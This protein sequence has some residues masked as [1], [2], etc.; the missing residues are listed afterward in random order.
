VI[1]LASLILVAITLAL[2]F[3]PVEFDA[4]ARQVAELLLAVGAVTILVVSSMEH[5]R[6]Y[7]LEADRQHRCARKLTELYDQA[8]LDSRPR[9]V[10]ALVT[11]YHAVLDSYPDNHEPIDYEMFAV[12]HPEDF[13]T[14][15]WKRQ[16]VR[17][18]WYVFAHRAWVIAAAVMVVIF[19][20]VR[21]FAT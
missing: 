3:D 1:S 12:R 5:G 15:W 13:T 2:G 7:Q 4:Q 10:P 20:M 21:L 18:A 11:E 17:A 19:A 9:D 6:G 14:G 8:N 16:R